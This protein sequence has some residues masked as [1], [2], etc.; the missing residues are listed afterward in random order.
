MIS[1]K[2]LTSHDFLCLTTATS[3]KTYGVKLIAEGFPHSSQDTETISCAE[4][5]FGA[6]GVFF[7]VSGLQASLTVYHN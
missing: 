4:T 7:A 1:P 2:A 5:P 3:A 6:H